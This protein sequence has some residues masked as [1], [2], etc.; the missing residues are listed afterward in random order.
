MHYPIISRPIVVSSKTLQPTTSTQLHNNVS[1]WN[2]KSFKLQNES[3]KHPL[4]LKHE[5]EIFHCDIFN[6]NDE[7]DENFVVNE[8]IN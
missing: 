7:N 4:N 1:L 8:S 2:V 5:M 6:D 3:T